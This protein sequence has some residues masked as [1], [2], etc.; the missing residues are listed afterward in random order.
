MTR[1]ALAPYLLKF[2][3]MAFQW[4]S[5]YSGRVLGV[6]EI[7]NFI[8]DQ[9]ITYTDYFEQRFVIAPA[10][11]KRPEKNSPGRRMSALR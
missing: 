8:I 2:R 10:L 11:A 7:A 5:G 9:T 6:V 4:I 1:G 3:A